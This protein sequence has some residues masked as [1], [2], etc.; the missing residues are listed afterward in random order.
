MSLIKWNDSLSINIAD[1]DQQ[2]RKLVLMI[3]ELNDAMREGQG[4]SMLGRIVNGLISYTGVHFRT[5]E[6]YFDQFEYSDADSH[7]A[8]HA[9]FVNKVNVFKD[10]FE[11]NRIGLSIDIMNFLSEWLTKH[12]KG[13]DKKY[14][15]FLIDKGLM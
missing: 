12:I 6:K 11:N 14:A 8:E 7:K 15:P 13:S 4:K 3:N 10:D 9:E 5:E 1:I 2:H